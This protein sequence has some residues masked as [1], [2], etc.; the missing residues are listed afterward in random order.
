MKKFRKFA[1]ISVGLGAVLLFIALALWS[2]TRSFVA[3]AATA[4]GMV[5]ELIEVRD[6]EGGSSTYKPVVKFTAP[7]GEQISFTSSYSSR[8]SAY[9]VGENVEVLYLPND[10]NDAR[11]KGFGSLWLGPL[12]LTGLGAVFS[13]IG[14]SILYAGRTRAQRQ[15][16]LKS[17]GTPILT[18]L[19][20]VDRNTDVRVNGR[21]PWRITSQWLDPST[22]KMRVFH[23]ENLWF[24]PTRFVKSRQLTVLLDPHDPRSYHLDV[25][26]LPELDEGK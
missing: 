25:S 6:S 16:Y 8:P 26:F 3:R 13:L 11:I 7:G 23:S 19:Q 14:A 24:D 18:D 9:D 4:P 10:A 12:I 1:F 5:T 17:A 15:A 22:N 2:K 21:H 20:G